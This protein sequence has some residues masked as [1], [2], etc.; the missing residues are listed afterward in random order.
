MNES[1]PNYDAWKLQT[2]PHYDSPPEK[3]KLDLTDKIGDTVS[4]WVKRRGLVG[5]Y[6]VVGV[7]ANTDIG[8]VWINFMGKYT[9]YEYD[10]MKEEENE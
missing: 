3:H 4:F 6:C 2:P 8:G 9:Y 1:I 10:D 5:L 7:V